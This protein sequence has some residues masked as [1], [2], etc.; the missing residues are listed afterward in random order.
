MHFSKPNFVLDESWWTLWLIRLTALF[1]GVGP[2]GPGL[3]LNGRGGIDAF[4]LWT[5]KREALAHFLSPATNGSGQF[6][7]VGSPLENYMCLCGVDDAH[8]GVCALRMMHKRKAPY[9]KRMDGWIER[10]YIGCP[11]GR[12]PVSRPL[13]RL[14]PQG[15]GPAKK[16][17]WPSGKYTA[18]GWDEEAR[19]RIWRILIFHL[20]AFC[21]RENRRAS[22]LDRRTFW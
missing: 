5:P 10:E 6:R 2:S 21:R 4:I 7:G 20:L 13:S 15:S 8:P 19:R 11:E 22:S 18:C 16:W 1:F 9:L 3:S 17:M 14:C 12:A